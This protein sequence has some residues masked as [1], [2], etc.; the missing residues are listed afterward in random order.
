MLTIH[1]M[2]GLKRAGSFNPDYLHLQRLE[3]HRR[4]KGP[5]GLPL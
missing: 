4:A 5:A 3:R 2:V 1:D